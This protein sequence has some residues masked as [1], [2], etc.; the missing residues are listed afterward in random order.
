MAADAKRRIFDALDRICV[1]ASIGTTKLFDHVTAI[2]KCCFN[3]GVHWKTFKKYEK[4]VRAY[5]K[6]AGKVGLS[7]G[8]EE[9]INSPSP[10]LAT[11]EII[12]PEIPAKIYYTKLLTLRCV[13]GIYSN[14][15]DLLHTS[16]SSVKVPAELPPSEDGFECDLRG[17]W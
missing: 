6:C 5:I 16:K 13:V 10:E 14:A 12:E 1:D 3:R 17:Q 4:E 7:R 2:A 15:F 8:I 11:A 9:G